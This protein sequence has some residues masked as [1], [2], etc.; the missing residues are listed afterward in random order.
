MTMP[1]DCTP[2]TANTRDADERSY[3][4]AIVAFTAL[5]LTPLVALV[6]VA[7]TASLS[8]GSDAGADGAQSSGDG[9]SSGSSA[10]ATSGSSAGTSAGTSAG[11]CPET[12]VACAPGTRFDD[13]TCGCTPVKC[14]KASDCMFLGQVVCDTAKG[15]CT[16]A[17]TYPACAAIKT[18]DN[19]LEGGQ[20]CDCTRD[21]ECDPTNTKGFGATFC[22]GPRHYCEPHCT[23][24]PDPALYCS[25][26]ALGATCQSNGL[27]AVACT[28]A[29]D[30]TNGDFG[31]RCGTNGFCCASSSPSGA[32]GACN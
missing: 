28:S 20:S 2:R 13:T 3:R 12:P 26:L 10:G 16:E 25:C 9:A 23:D 19:G 5:A 11:H 27:C 30:C 24:Q 21:S 17:Y 31:D 7:C 6:A 18:C 1:P 14:T 29:S 4:R 8:L 32:A 15:E 22:M